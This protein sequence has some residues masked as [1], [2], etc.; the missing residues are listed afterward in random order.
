VRMR[1]SP[2]SRRS[3]TS[4]RKTASYRQSAA[5]RMRCRVERRF[6]ALA[7]GEQ[8]EGLGHRRAVGHHGEPELV[9]D[10]AALRARLG[11]H[12]GAHSLVPRDERDEHVDRAGAVDRPFRPTA[13]GSTRCGSPATSPRSAG[14]SPPA[15]APD[16][17][18][19]RRPLKLGLPRTDRLRPQPGG[20]AT[21][22]RQPRHI[23]HRG[24]HDNYHRR[25][26]HRRR[27]QKRAAAYVDSWDKATN[28]GWTVRELR[29]L[30]LPEPPPE[31]RPKTRKRRKP[32]EMLT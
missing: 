7:A 21:R 8:R 3:M 9:G 25:R 14:R 12:D 15:P 32:N 28:A 24:R 10:L 30:R 22:H 17:P 31:Y 13:T 1:P 26:H 23:E 18:H 16:P 19:H 29:A 2:W 4:P 5:G 11:D 27:L 6:S 20:R